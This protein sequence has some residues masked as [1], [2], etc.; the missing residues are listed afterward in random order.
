MAVRTRNGSRCALCTRHTNGRAPTA[1]LLPVVGGGPDGT[2][3]PSAGP[4]CALQATPYRCQFGTAAR[5][6]RS[7]TVP[8]V[9]KFRV[10]A[11]PNA[12][13]EVRPHHAAARRRAPRPHVCCFLRSEPWLCTALTHVVLRPCIWLT[14]RAPSA[15]QRVRARMRPRVHC[16]GWHAECTCIET[17]CCVV[18]RKTAK[19]GEA[20]FSCDTHPLSGVACLLKRPR[21]AL[22]ICTLR[23]PC[24]SP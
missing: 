20:L 22:Q 16:V 14:V 13:H 12:L 4:H 19:A 2:L 10:S 23:H 1:S 8:P 15:A 24:R 21:P 9:L 6:S 7:C 18:R 3:P 11:S 5:P 17:R